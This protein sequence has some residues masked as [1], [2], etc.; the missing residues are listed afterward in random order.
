MELQTNRSDCVLETAESP[1]GA[2]ELRANQAKL[3]AVTLH[4]DTGF[5]ALKAQDNTLL[6][7][8]AYSVHP[9]PVSGS[10]GLEIEAA[11]FESPFKASVAQRLRTT[12]LGKLLLAFLGFP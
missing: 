3:R 1:R 12:K 9:W 7:L 5:L 4:V 11:G 6:P 10:L 8:K 2:Q